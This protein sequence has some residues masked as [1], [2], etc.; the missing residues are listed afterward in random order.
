MQLG[1]TTKKWTRPHT[2]RGQKLK[3][4][5]DVF[6]SLIWPTLVSRWLVHKMKTKLLCQLRNL[7]LGKHGPRTKM[8]KYHLRSKQT[9][10]KEKLSLQLKVQWPLADS[11]KCS[12]VRDFICLPKTTSVSKSFYYKS[13]LQCSSIKTTSPFIHTPTDQPTNYIVSW[14][15]TYLFSDHRLFACYDPRF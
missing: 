12:S 11:C 8:P 10:R 7:G 3:L 5:V 13:N 2:N 1:I 14:N 15:R 6:L 4:S 9:Q